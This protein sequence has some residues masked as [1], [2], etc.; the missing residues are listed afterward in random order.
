MYCTDITDDTRL[1]KAIYLIV[2][3]EYYSLGVSGTGVGLESH[4][5]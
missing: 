1:M 5:G 2:R 4:P 3:V